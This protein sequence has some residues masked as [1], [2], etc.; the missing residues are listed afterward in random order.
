MTTNNNTN[1]NNNNNNNMTTTTTTTV[2]R[3]TSFQ[4]GL[5]NLM[6][7]KAYLFAPN[8][9]HKDILNQLC[10][11]VNDSEYKSILQKLEI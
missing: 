10:D 2:S 4:T 3:I 8:N 6:N 11:S 1:N 9:E 7:L 5:S